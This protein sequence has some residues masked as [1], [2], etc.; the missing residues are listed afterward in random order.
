MK[1]RP[2]EKWLRMRKVS[3]RLLSSLTVVS[4]SLSVII[5]LTEQLQK[6]LRRTFIKF[7]NPPPPIQS[8]LIKAGRLLFNLEFVSD[9]S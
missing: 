1:Y 4:V 7:S 8:G 9:L 3:M 5:S 6:A 2:E